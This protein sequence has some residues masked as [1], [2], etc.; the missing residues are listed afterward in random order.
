[1]LVNITAFVDCKTNLNHSHLHSV[2]P[3]LDTVFN[4]HF[5]AIEHAALFQLSLF[6]S[7]K[8]HTWWEHIQR[9]TVTIQH[10]LTD[11]EVQ[12]Y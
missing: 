2:Y 10:V 5:N 6:K 7:R 8:D 11:E 3:C 4:M 9:V 12:N 1:M